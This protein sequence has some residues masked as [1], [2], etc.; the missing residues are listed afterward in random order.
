M[1]KKWFGTW[2]AHC[3]LCNAE[4]ANKEF[5]VDGAT[6][7]RGQWALMCPVCFEAFG[8]GLGPGRGQKYDSKTLEKLEVGINLGRVFFN[9]GKDNF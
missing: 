1:K 4:L 6:S 9:S 5:F 8:R 3:D 7:F 2:P